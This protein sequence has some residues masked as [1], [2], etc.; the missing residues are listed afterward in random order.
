MSALRKK[1]SLS[2]DEGGKELEGFMEDGMPL[3]VQWLFQGVPEERKC[4]ATVIFG[5][6]GP[7]IRKTGSQP[8]EEMPRLQAFADELGAQENQG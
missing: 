6:V 3:I 5:L 4:V 8:F 7:S 2:Q 1:R